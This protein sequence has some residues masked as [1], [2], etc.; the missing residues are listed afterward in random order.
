[1]KERKVHSSPGDA[2]V[3]TRGVA[4]GNRDEDIPPSR[5]DSPRGQPEP[6]SVTPYEYIRDMMDDDEEDEFFVDD[7]SIYSPGTQA[8]LPLSGIQEPLTFRERDYPDFEETCAVCG[9]N[10][11]DHTDFIMPCSPEDLWESYAQRYLTITPSGWTA[12]DSPDGIMITAPGREDYYVLCNAERQHRGA[13]GERWSW[14]CHKVGDNGDPCD[15]DF[16]RE[17][18]S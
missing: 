2:G 7:G 12:T 10:T 1:M 5:P 6:E 14:C 17:I 3:G 4:L 11:L 16:M 18:S 15:E 8:G 9:T 13:Y